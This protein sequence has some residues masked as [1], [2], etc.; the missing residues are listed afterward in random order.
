M[1]RYAVS[2]IPKQLKMRAFLQEILN[3]FISR[4]FVPKSHNLEKNNGLHW[5]SKR[6]NARID[7]SDKE[8]VRG[9]IDHQ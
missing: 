8:A 1:R 9:V 2:A 5:G 6:M 3:K 4:R 7:L